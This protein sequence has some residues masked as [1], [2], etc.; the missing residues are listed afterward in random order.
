MML[1][2]AG[3]LGQA[4][5]LAGKPPRD[6]RRRLPPPTLQVLYNGT[7]LNQDALL[8]RGSAQL[9]RLQLLGPGSD[10]PL[11]LRPTCVGGSSSRTVTLH[12]PTQ[13]AAGFCWAVSHRAQGAV[14]VRPRLIQV[15][16]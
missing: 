6:R 14:Q 3:G 5:K 9:P 15:R 8:L 11:R 2:L 13:V 1:L 4:A 7:S 16:A 10:G 12:N